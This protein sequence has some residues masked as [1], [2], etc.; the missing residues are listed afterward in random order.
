MLYLF[1]NIQEEFL[2]LDVRMFNVYVLYLNMNL[3]ELL[4]CL[5]ICL[6]GDELEHEPTGTGLC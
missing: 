3:L 1:I 2:C 4:L 6:S 5:Y